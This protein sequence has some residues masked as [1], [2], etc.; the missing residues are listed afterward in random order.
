MLMTLFCNGGAHG[1]CNPYAAI[2]IFVIGIPLLC[3]AIWIMEK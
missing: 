2:V 1:G 3:L